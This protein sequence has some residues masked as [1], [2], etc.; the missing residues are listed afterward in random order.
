MDLRYSPASISDGY[1]EMKWLGEVPSLWKIECF[2]IWSFQLVILVV[3]RATLL[4]A[5]FDVLR[6]GGNDF[7]VMEKFPLLTN[8]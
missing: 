7:Y 6:F 5:E 4:P 1:M 8:V 3:G 2:P